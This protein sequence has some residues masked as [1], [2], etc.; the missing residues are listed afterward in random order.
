[1]K[2]K[3]RIDCLQ[4]FIIARGGCGSKVDNEPEDNTNDHGGTCNT[5]PG[6]LKNTATSPSPNEKHLPRQIPKPM[7]PII[8]EEALSDDDAF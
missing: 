4:E 7:R 3:E 2:G 8:S 1:L 6:G 5:D